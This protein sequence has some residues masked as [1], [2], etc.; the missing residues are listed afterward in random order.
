MIITFDIDGT[1]CSQSNP[2][3]ENAQPFFEKIE[4][5]NKLYY[6]GHTIN[7]FTS[8]FMGRTNSDIKKVYEIGY[9]FTYNQLKNWNIKFHNLYMGKPMYDFFID[10]KFID[11]KD[12]WELRILKIIEKG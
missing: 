8:R 10:D 4:V 12:D 11:Y 1:I 3:Y 6:E 7:F 2:D 9:D 5:I